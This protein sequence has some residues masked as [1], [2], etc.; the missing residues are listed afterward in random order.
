[1]RLEVTCDSRLASRDVGLIFACAVDDKVAYEILTATLSWAMESHCIAMPTLNSKNI[2]FVFICHNL[3]M[4]R[5]KKTPRNFDPRR[6]SYTAKS[7][8]LASFRSSETR[9]NSDGT[10]EVLMVP[11][12][13]CAAFAAETLLKAL[14]TL[15]KKPVYD[16]HFLLK[17]FNELNDETKS[18]ISKIMVITEDFLFEKIKESSDAFSYFRYIHEK[19]KGKADLAFLQNFANKLQLLVEKNL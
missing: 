18:E 12:I 9:Q 17:I 14:L 13:V 8:L 3:F 5:H 6:A 7:F 11:A 15:E 4:T 19:E 1:M 2:N 16:D 10:F